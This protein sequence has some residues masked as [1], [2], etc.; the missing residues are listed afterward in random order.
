[1]KT[2]TYGINSLYK[3]ASID[4]QAGPWWAFFLERMVEWC[5]DLVPDIPLPNVRLR[6]RDPEDIELNDGHQ[7][8]TWK[9]WYGD[10]SQLFHCF[11]HIPVFNYCQRRIRSKILELDYDRAKEMFYEEDKEFWDK[12]QELIKDQ[13]DRI[14][15]RR[16]YDEGKEKATISVRGAGTALRV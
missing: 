10:L 16:L 3:T 2:W 11:V 13:N 9:E 4:L 6:L 5:C 15:E 12:E 1:V 8:T 7:V 14:F